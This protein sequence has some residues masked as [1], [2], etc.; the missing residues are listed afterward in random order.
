MKRT[1]PFL[2]PLLLAWMLA[3]P[4][5]AAAQQ[6][7]ESDL[8]PLKPMR[9]PGQRIAGL[10]P[11]DG[12]RTILNHCIPNY[13]VGTSDGDFIAG[14]SLGTI[15][16]GSG[17]ASDPPFYT[18]F[19]FTDPTSTTRLMAGS[20]YT[21][22]V[23][24]GTYAL[25]GAEYE[26]IAAWIN[27]SHREDGTFSDAE[28]LGY[29]QATAAGQVVSITFTI[30]VDAT[31]GYTTLRVRLAYNAT[32]AG[33]G[34]CN[35][36]DYGETEDY[37]LL[38]EGP[39][40]IPLMN[41]GT[42]DGDSISAVSLTSLSYVADGES[43]WNFPDQP[44]SDLYYTG[45]QLVRGQS[46]TL[47]VSIGDYAPNRV[48]AW[49]DWNFDGDYEDAGEHLGEQVVS[50]AFGTASFTVAVPATALVGY[51]S[52][53]VRTHFGASNTEP[54]ATLGFG[55]A[56]D[57]SVS[58]R[59]GA[60]PCLSI[61][62]LGTDYG[63]GFAQ[64]EYQGE[65]FNGTTEWPYFQLAMN[66]FQATQ[67]EAQAFVIQSG[68]WPTQTYAAYLDMN[69]D[70]DFDDAGEALGSVDATSAN[71][72]LNLGFTVPPTCPPGQHALRLRAFFNIDPPASPCANQSFGEIIDFQLAVQAVGGP[73]MPHL[74][75]WTMDGDF[76]N[77]VSL[78]TLSNPNTGATYGPAYTDYTSLSTTLAIGS[79]HTI[80]IQ[81][82]AYAGDYYRAFL[83]YNGD[84]DWDDAGEVLG[85]VS[86]PDAFGTGTITFTVPPAPPG[87]KRLRIR[88]RFVE[89][90]TA[91]DDGGYGETEDYSVVIDVGSGLGEATA[92][93]AHVIARPGDGVATLRAAERHLGSRFEVLD[94]TGRRI[95]AGQV[96]ATTVDMPMTTAAAGAY[97]LL[98]HGPAGL[99]ALRFAWER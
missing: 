16:V 25:S 9:A 66:P 37:T 20:T 88:C 28:K 19:S 8:R 90:F 45:A 36:Y 95:A 14:V 3:A 55:E 47:Q 75:N 31:P 86:I 4:S 61:T 98:L 76:I 43:A 32:A 48:N 63:D 52:M 6:H 99:E 13:D 21:L 80:T 74:S 93:A 35:D 65:V 56:M 11:R 97:T 96:T 85:M 71:Q 18:D 70:G 53:R 24:N 46:H 81:G 44:Y 68:T 84:N 72:V 87:T 49:I 54:C 92:Q 73:C 69:D 60:Y 77:S 58:I 41:Y 23:T 79:T 22:Q 40:C 82:G 10:D 50:T 62:G 15:N 89:N 12:S 51:T 91:C 42:I 17:G 1:L 5:A 7:P 33:L 83:D 57:F 38:I 78:N 67:G 2:Q 27:L 59:A 26:G 39:A 29:A 34:P 30:P 94:A 64:V